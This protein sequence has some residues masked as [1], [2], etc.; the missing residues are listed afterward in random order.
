MLWDSGCRDDAGTG[1]GGS[2]SRHQGLHLIAVERSRTRVSTGEDEGQ[3]RSGEGTLWRPGLRAPG[4]Q[5][6]K[7][8]E[9]GEEHC[10]LKWG[11][12][13]GAWTLR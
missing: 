10:S 7:T 8:P 9:E 2:A 5:E 1:E 11:R 6:G 4:W 13:G 3:R 12:E